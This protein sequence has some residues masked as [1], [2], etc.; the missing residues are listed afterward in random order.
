MFSEFFNNLKVLFL[1][2]VYTVNHCFNNMHCSLSE[3]NSSFGLSETQY[4]SHSF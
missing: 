4:K 2:R 1:D 3:Q